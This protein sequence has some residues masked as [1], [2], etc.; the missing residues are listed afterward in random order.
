MVDVFTKCCTIKEL[1]V[2]EIIKVP[3]HF[4]IECF[5]SSPLGKIEINSISEPHLCVY[6]YVE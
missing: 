1:C 2:K 6:A 5:N 4:V 3:T